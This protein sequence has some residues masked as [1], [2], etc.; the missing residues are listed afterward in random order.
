M[1]ESHRYYVEWKKP[2]TKE[3]IPSDSI[4][5]DFKDRQNESME[6][7]S[8]SSDCLLVEYRSR[9]SMR[10]PYGVLYPGWWL[11][12]NTGYVDIYTQVHDMYITHIC[13]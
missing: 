10:E 4:Y 11:H 6:D 7:R 12:T 3:R 5:V 1:D 9:N 8:Q 13:Q 2:D